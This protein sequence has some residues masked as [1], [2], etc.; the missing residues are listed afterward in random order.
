MI[1]QK[2]GMRRF[3]I[4][5]MGQLASMIGSGLIGFALSVWIFKVTGQ[6]TPFAL[7]AL[8]STLPRILLSPVAGALTDRWNRK[9]IMI[10][11]DSLSGLLTLLVA[12]LLSINQ[13]EVWMIYLISFLGS[14]F[15]SFQQP[16]YSASIVM[17][18]PKDQLTRANS[19]VQMGQAL[20]SLI[21]PVLAG[22]LVVSIGMPGI[23]LIDI[24]TFIIALIAL[25]FVP[26]PQ[27]ELR[28]RETGAKR[29]MFDDIR[30]GWQ[31]LVERRGLL[32]LILYFACVNF[33]MNLAFI[34]VGP[35]VLSF[36]SATNMGIAQSV[37]G[38]G[39][40]MGSLLMSLWGGFKKNKILSVIGF[41]T[42]ASLGFLVMGL[43]PSLL[44]VSAGIFM[45]AFFL[46]FGSGPSS[47]LFA[48]KVDPA[49]QGR[50]FATRSM[51]SQS[52]M[53]LAFLLS[54]ILADNVFSPLMV[55]GGHLAETF[56][57]DLIGVGLGRGIGLM[58]I[59]SGLLLILISILAYLN[60]KI[61]NIEKEI[62]DAI[63]ETHE[64]GPLERDLSEKVTA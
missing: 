10:I 5:W 41:I 22:V 53:P 18:V 21:T 57:G 61:R 52:M 39:M 6:A 40:L 8:F 17:L 9:K 20:E 60:P 48:E 43:H 54:G 42:L 37:L 45:L 35:L 47:A 46:P 63:S 24:I 30:F 11:S 58:I 13:M 36:G 23:I 27:P 44:M 32:G 28:T 62:P 3:L 34:M 50:V 33:F 29:S 56:I 4:I 16:A 19:M 55:D 49:V 7:T 26:I 25:V 51:I 59:C 12:V 64:D 14:I 15:A 1:Q 38:A 31:Y 2:I